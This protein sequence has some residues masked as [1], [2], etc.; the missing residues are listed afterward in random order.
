MCILDRLTCP[1]SY[2]KTE[3]KDLM[4]KREGP[5]LVPLKGIE[6]VSDNLLFTYCGNKIVFFWVGSF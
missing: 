4:R 1:Y 6:K 5:I 3:L 2:R